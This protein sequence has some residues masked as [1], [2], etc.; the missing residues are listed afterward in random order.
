MIR[1]SFNHNA[2]ASLS[3]FKSWIDWWISFERG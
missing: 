2:W 1:V 3:L